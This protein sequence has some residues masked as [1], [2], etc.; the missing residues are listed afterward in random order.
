MSGREISEGLRIGAIA[1]LEHEKDPAKVGE[2]AELAFYLVLPFEKRPGLYW[3]LFAAL[4][5]RAGGEKWF[6]ALT[7][8]SVEEWH[9]ER[10]RR[11]KAATAK[12]EEANAKDRDWLKPRAAGLRD[13]S[14]VAALGYASE[15]YNGYREEVTETMGS[16]ESGHGLLATPN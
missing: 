13:G 6:T 2:L 11:R 7:S 9:G 16:T 10:A 5:G 4:E 1:A 8:G 3:R 15:V 14:H 12:I